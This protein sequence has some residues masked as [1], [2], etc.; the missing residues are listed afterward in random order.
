MAEYGLRS[1]NSSQL[2]DLLK[3]RVHAPFSTVLL[4]VV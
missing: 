1:H 3:G 4:H 2:D